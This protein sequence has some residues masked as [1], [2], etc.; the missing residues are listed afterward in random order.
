MN[1]LYAFIFAIILMVGSAQARCISNDAWRGEDKLFH[2]VAGSTISLA[3]GSQYRNP[4]IGFY[5]GVAAGAIKE[6]H[7]MH[8]YHRNTCS[9]QDFV[10]TVI[11]AGLGS[12]ASKWSIQ[13]R[14]NG[15]VINFNTE[16]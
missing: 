14:D 7:D 5:S 2:F 16:F 10:V 1:K 8:Y 6:L 11:G 4:S 12:Y 13:A 3:V 9:L 15:L